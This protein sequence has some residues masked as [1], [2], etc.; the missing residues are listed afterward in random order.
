[1]TSL[2]FS[3]LLYYLFFFWF[4]VST[5][6]VPRVFVSLVQRNGKPTRW[7]RG[8]KTLGT[9][10]GKHIKSE[11]LCMRNSR[12]MRTQKHWNQ[13]VVPLDVVLDRRTMTSIPEIS[14]RGSL[15]LW[16]KFQIPVGP[17]PCAGPRSGREGEKCRSLHHMRQIP[18]VNPAL[19]TSWL[20][21]W[22][23]L[24]LSKRQSM[25]SQTVLLRTTL[26]RMIALYLMTYYTGINFSIYTKDFYSFHP[27]GNYIAS[28][29]DVDLSFTHALFQNYL[30]RSQPFGGYEKWNF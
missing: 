11:K 30:L 9:R 25:S 18:Y 24:R 7:S 5:N 23:P 17:R 2:S 27:Y 15:I 6:L 28:W 8:T 13:S 22:L 21:R 26:T 10:L 20:W 14:A 12:E 16:A 3:S 4:L 29:Y 19:F 1:M